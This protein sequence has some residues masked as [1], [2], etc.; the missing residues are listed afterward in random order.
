MSQRSKEEDKRPPHGMVVY[1]TIRWNKRMERGQ[2]LRTGLRGFEFL[3]S[4]NKR[5]KQQAANDSKKP[6]LRSIYSNLVCLQ[7]IAN[8]TSTKMKGKSLVAKTRIGVAITTALLLGPLLSAAGLTSA[9]TSAYTSPLPSRSQGSPRSRIVRYD[10]ADDGSPSDYD[11]SD[12]PPVIKE[13]AVDEKEE[14]IAIRD[15]LKRELLL[16]ASVTDRGAYCSK[17]EKDIVID[18]VAQLEALNP[19]KDPASNCE[20]E[21]DLGYASTQ[22]FRSSPFFQSIRSAV[23]DENKGVAEN[24]F[25]L[26]AQATSG[27]RVGR[28][29]QIIT[30]EKLISEVDLEVGMLPGI[31][32]SL[33][34][35]VVTT[36]ALNVVSDKRWELKIENTKVKGSNIPLFNTFMDDLLQVE[37]PVGNFYNSL[38]GKVPVIPLTT[39]YADDT[40][41]ITRDVDEN[42]FVFI[43]E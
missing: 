19:T 27:S 1:G 9:F 24:G 29:R 39:F 11:T 36:S 37:L 28:V 30:S 33:K 20:G 38:Q 12:L 4:S 25:A 18:L 43:R 6:K 34:G 2:S 23:G 17:E 42:F 21:W 22:L 41:R 13:V 5:S 35:T 32:M 31:P 3:P 16:L 10:Y 8:S 40:L 14:D 15:D 7:R 26:H